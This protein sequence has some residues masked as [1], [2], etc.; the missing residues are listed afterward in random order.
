MNS[1]AA[2][3]FLE[4]FQIAHTLGSPTFQVPPGPATSGTTN[5]CSNTFGLVMRVEWKAEMASWIQLATPDAR[6]RLSE[7]SS[8]ENTSGVIP[9][10]YRALPNLR[11]SRISWESMAMFCPL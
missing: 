6:K 5:V 9:S 10:S 8:H 3:T 4:N 2:A 11:D 7:A 1:L